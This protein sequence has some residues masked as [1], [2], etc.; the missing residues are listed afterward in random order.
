MEN[1]FMRLDEAVTKKKIKVEDG[2][3]T[4]RT[5]FGPS[6][7]PFRDILVEKKTSFRS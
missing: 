1:R 3:L 7:T 5:D 4:R 6:S 2:I